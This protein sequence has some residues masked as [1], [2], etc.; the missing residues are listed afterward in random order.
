MSDNRTISEPYDYR[1]GCERY[2]DRILQ[3]VELA[4]NLSS[5]LNQLFTVIAVIFAVFVITLVFAVFSRPG[6]VS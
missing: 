4:D 5:T 1:D 2:S 6:G 3:P